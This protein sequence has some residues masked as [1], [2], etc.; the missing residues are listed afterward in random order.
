NPEKFNLYT[1]VYSNSELVENECIEKDIKLIIDVPVNAEVFAD[2]N[3]INT[4]IR[5]LLTNAIKYTEKGKITVNSRLINNYHEIRITDTGIGI[6][7][8]IRITIFKL[9]NSKSLQGTRGESGTGLGL[10][11]CKEFV[12]KNGGTIRVESKEGEGSSFIFT[13]PTAT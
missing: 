12:E 3:M 1:L 6:S 7:D 4:V 10:I 2:Q 13:V 8:D 9:D 5:N 11:I